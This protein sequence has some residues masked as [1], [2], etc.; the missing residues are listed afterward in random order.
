MV[1]RFGRSVTMRMRF[2]CRLSKKRQHVELSRVWVNLFISRCC[3]ATETWTARSPAA[4]RTATN[5]FQRLS[6][7]VK[8]QAPTKE[9]KVSMAMTRRAAEG[10]WSRPQV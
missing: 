3:P 7:E 9:K 6:E 2:S 8:A 10:D 4:S 1:K 5:G